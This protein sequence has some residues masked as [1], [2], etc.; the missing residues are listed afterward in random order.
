MI[1]GL[2]VVYG[3]TTDFCITVAANED[4]AAR[5]ANEYFP[6]ATCV[7]VLNAEDVLH[8]QYDNLAI[9]GTI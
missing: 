5:L 6:D 7:E 8:E 2:R 3:D 9:L 1:Y 4:E